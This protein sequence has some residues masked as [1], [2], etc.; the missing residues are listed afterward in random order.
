MLMVYFS[1]IL[2]AWCTVVPEK[3]VF[4]ILALVT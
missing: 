2:K 3:K 4:N 1:A